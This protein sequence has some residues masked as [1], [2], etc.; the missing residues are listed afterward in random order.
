MKN[1]LLDF[2]FPITTIVPT[3]AASTAYL[4]QAFLVV[5]PKDGVTAGQVVECTTP[6]AVAALTDNTEATA[7]FTAGMNRVFL[8]VADTL[9]LASLMEDYGQEAFTLLISSDY[10]TANVTA[11]NAGV[12][13]GVI[14]YAASDMSFLRAQ[15]VI[16]NRVAF[17]AKAETGAQNMLYAFGKLL[18]STINWSSQ[19]YISMLMSDDVDVLG[20]A[21][22]LFDDRISFV[23]TDKQYSNRLGLFAAGGKAIVA[24][25]VARNLEIDLQSKALQYISANQP[26]YTLV[27]AALLQDELQKVIDLYVT[28]GW[29]TQGSVEV[30][31]EAEN[32]VATARMVVPEAKSLWRI[33][34]EVRQAVE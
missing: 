21:D 34:G 14:G 9:N 19:Q 17:F 25:Y 24:P 15:A 12:F 30:T 1:I 22:G 8:V 10:S 27:Q 2:I 33:L 28:R 4:K 16:Q 18:S 7:L 11:L 20:D 13:N 26:A 3:P 31:L 6:G 23:L 5:K 32:F 29:I